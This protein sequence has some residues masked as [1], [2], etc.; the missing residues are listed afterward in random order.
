MMGCGCHRWR[1]SWWLHASFN[2]SPKAWKTTP[3]RNDLA[4]R[5]KHILSPKECT[6]SNIIFQGADQRLAAWSVSWKPSKTVLDLKNF[7]LWGEFPP[8]DLSRVGFW[9]HPL[10]HVPLSSIRRFA[11]ISLKPPSR[12]KWWIPSSHWSKLQIQQARDQTIHFWIQILKLSNS[13]LMPSA[14][15]S[16]GFTYTSGVTLLTSLQT[17]MAPLPFQ[18]KGVATPIS[19]LCISICVLSPR[20]FLWKRTGGD[21]SHSA[22]ISLKSN[23]LYIRSY[24][25]LIKRSEYSRIKGYIV[26]YLWR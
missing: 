1:G 24:I 25:W 21:I 11:S 22:L 5:P 23:W 6:I 15:H 17:S 13:K 3:K 18:L 10:K 16:T 26:V 14:S 12:K 2:Q 9:G 8:R 4:R 20:G 7:F 19:V